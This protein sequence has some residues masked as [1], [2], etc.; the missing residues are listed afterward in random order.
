MAG[1]PERLSASARA[2]AKSRAMVSTRRIGAG[3]HGQEAPKLPNI[4]TRFCQYPGGARGRDGPPEGADQL[5]LR[6]LT[7]GDHRSRRPA[8]HPRGRARS[9][10]RL[11][12]LLRRHRAGLHQIF[13]G[14]EQE[15][16]RHRPARALDRDRLPDPTALTLVTR[17]NG[18]EMQRSGTDMLIHSIPAMIAFCSVFTPLAP[19]DVIATGTPTASV[20]SA[21]LGLDEARRRAGGGD[22]QHRHAANTD[23]GREVKQG[24]RINWL[25]TR[26]S[27]SFR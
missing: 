11:Y 20:P 8:H 16:L 21:P 15:L 22:L 17:L 26:L 10:S 9:R 1:S 18:Q 4:F 25:L 3:E 13:A 24:S 12:L 23:R 19:S 2:L 6:R 5:R 7:G 14:G 27:P